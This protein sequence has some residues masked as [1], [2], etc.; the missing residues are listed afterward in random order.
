M[1]PHDLSFGEWGRRVLDLD[2]SL[3]DAVKAVSTSTPMLVVVDQLDALASTV[4]LTSSRL[5]ELVGF[6][7]R[8]SELPNVS[9]LCSC[10]DF[11]Y[12]YDTRFR[13]L[14][15][16][17][18]S[19]ALP[20][21]ESV[22]EHL[23]S[24]GITNAND[25]SDDFKEVLRTPQHLGVFLRSYS[26]TGNTSPFDSYQTML[27]DFWSRAVV[28]SEERNLLQDLT[29]KLV[30]TESIWTPLVSFQD[31]SATIA[32]L[33]AKGVLRIEDQSLGFAHQTLLEYA[34][35]RY[36]TESE[37]SLTLSFWNQ[38]DKIQYWSDQR[39]GPYLPTFVVPM[40]IAIAKRSNVFF[41]AICV[42]I[43]DFY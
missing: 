2:V 40:N 21:W 18:I 43:F 27:G 1:F 15:S 28:S 38:D 9:V 6:V 37:V 33:Q 42:C 8:C 20:T 39:F 5:N 30:S 14:N 11:D 7:T 25:W 24:H 26:D 23:T 19:L 4:D 36:F 16:R 32:A 29:E 10:R 22:S 12:T 41:Q 34:K 13:R 3:F 31:S 17:T 35:A